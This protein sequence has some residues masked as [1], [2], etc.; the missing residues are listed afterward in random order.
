[1]NSFRK[2]A[3]PI[4]QTFQAEADID[5]RFEA[6][7]QVLWEKIY[8][9]VKSIDQSSFT[10]NRIRRIINMLSG[11]QRQNRKSIIATPIENADE[12]TASQF[13][14][15][16]LWVSN[17][18]SLL[19]LTSEVFRD[20][21]IVGL[22]MIELSMD[23]SSDP[24]SGDIKLSKCDYNSFIIDP[25]FK[26]ADLSDCN[27]IWRR[28]YLKR[29]ECKLLQPA[30][31]SLIES[32]PFMDNDGRF[33]GM[34][35]GRELSRTKLF[36]YDEFYYRA[37][38]NK[39]IL[40]DS[41]TGETVE[42]TGIN[43]QALERHLNLYP[44]INMVETIVPTVNLTVAIN[45]QVMY[46]G[47]NPLGLDNYPFVPFFADYNPN[48]QDYSLRIQGVVRGLRDPQFLYNRR[49]IIE[50]N[51]LESQI[52]SGWLFK[53][54]F[55]I[56][57]KSI[58]QVGEDKNIAVTKDAPSIQDA[59]QR[60]PSATWDPNI[61]KISEALGDE[62][63]IN[64][65]LSKEVF[66]TDNKD[67]SGI[68]AAYRHKAATA[69]LQGWFDSLDRSLRYVGERLISLMQLNFTPGKIQRIIEEQP[70]EQFYDR[71]FGKYDCVVEDGLNTATQKQMQFAQ[72]LQ[73]KEVGVNIPG[74]MLIE[75][76]PLQD[77]KALRESV[78]KAEQQMAEQ[79]QRKLEGDM[80][81]QEARTKL[82][83]SRAYADEGL[84]SE[85][86]SR[87]QENEALA[88]ERYA[89]AAKD[90][91]L[92]ELNIAKTLKE[93]DD[94]DISQM[95]KL[96]NIAIMMKTSE[97]ADRA[98]AL[99]RSAA[100]Q[101]AARAIANQPS[102]ARSAGVS[103]AVAQGKTASKLQGVRPETGNISR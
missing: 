19:E 6:G 58:H 36:A 35:E 57:K 70:S 47:H 100:D 92:G 20:T 63:E 89:E 79:E 44:Q 13:S 27:G 53:P 102:K 71:V 41:E 50:L 26:K 90:R 52:T 95:E 76:A 38:R 96:L 25:Y 72:L 94:V 32:L 67:I 49:K 101:G 7:D 77:K 98:Q 37:Y 75:Y 80:I 66:G 60:I 43:E 17:R 93:L 45:D 39:R 51:I 23:Y 10:F 62:M 99:Q 34:V 68:T 91:A 73:L 15:L 28:S 84:G 12:I 31:A 97:Q 5:T 59:A 82:A 21:L 46:D 14:K 24:I 33:E 1:M 30:K 40:S 48:I 8:K 18:E 56:D 29:A 83:E 64:V 55:L 11:H 4:N 9:S 54:D 78:A 86:I 85:R 87:I 81:E 2:I 65:G 61:T 74:E 42:W 22:S 69:G 3:L 88:V 103:Q 16:L